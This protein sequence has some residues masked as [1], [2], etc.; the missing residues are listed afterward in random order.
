MPSHQRGDSPSDTLSCYGAATTVGSFH[1]KQSGHSKVLSKAV[2]I[3][4]HVSVSFLKVF[5]FT[6]ILLLFFFFN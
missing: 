3:S 4:S 2:M 6:I 1:E 5:G